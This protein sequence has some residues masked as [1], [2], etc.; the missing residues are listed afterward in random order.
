MKNLQFKMNKINLSNYLV[1]LIILV[2]AISRILPHPPNFTP[3]AAIALFGSAHLKNKYL[4]FLIPISIVYLSDLFI[5]NFIYKEEFFRWF[6][7]GC[8]WQYSVYFLI[9]ILGIYLFNN[10]INSNKVLLGALMSSFMFFIISN[11]GVWFSGVMYSKDLTGLI[12]CYVAAIPFYKWTMLGDIFY[13]VI[14]FGGFYLIQ[15][16]FPVFRLDYIKYK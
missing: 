13:S 6:Y 12:S 2:A 9:I 11:F 4:V 7:D 16:K 8:L 3:L 14:L 5:N 15:K 1:F 10:K